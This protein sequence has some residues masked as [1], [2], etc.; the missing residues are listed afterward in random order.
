M[1]SGR[2]ALATVTAWRGLQPKLMSL[3]LDGLEIFDEDE[4]ITTD[5][6]L[7]DRA[8]PG[9]FSKALAPDGHLPTTMGRDNGAAV[10]VCGN[11]GNGEGPAPSLRNTS[12]IC[13]WRA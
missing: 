3:L 9:H 10:D 13:R 11:L 8:A 4:E 5:D 1:P 6:F 2:C 7:A 12:E